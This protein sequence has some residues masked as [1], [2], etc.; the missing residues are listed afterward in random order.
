MANRPPVRRRRPS[1]RRGGIQ[2]AVH[3][4]VLLIEA[5]REPAFPLGGEL[6]PGLRPLGDVLHQLERPGPAERLAQ[7]PLVGP[8]QQ[9]QQPRR[10]RFQ[11]R[12]EPVDLLLEQGLSWR[13]RGGSLATSRSRARRSLAIGLSSGPTSSGCSQTTSGGRSRGRPARIRPS[14]TVGEEAHH[15]V[16]RLRVQVLEQ[17]QAG[18]QLVHGRADLVRDRSPAIRSGQ[19]DQRDRPLRLG[20]P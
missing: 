5:A 10:Q 6:E 3:L 18:D 7:P 2:Q 20:S 4:R 19:L 14:R 9:L 15:D 12:P 16:G 17:H 13:S 1:A 8:S 11:R